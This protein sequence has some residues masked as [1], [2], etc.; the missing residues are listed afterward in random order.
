MTRV[1]VCSRS[2][3]RHPELRAELLARYPD[4][5]FNDDGLALAGSA[6][7]EYLKGHDAAVVGLE[8]VDDALLAAVPEIRVIAKY[9]VG[10][11]S[12]TRRRWRDAASS[13]AGPAA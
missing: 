11:E 4:T 13:W 2:F 7:A 3:S 10:M 9:G 1:A 8:V 12:S 6:L 5:T